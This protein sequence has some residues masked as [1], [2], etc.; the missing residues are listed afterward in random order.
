M[1]MCSGFSVRLRLRSGSLALKSCTARLAKREQ[2]REGAVEH[3]AA[4]FAQEA[5]GLL[6]P[7]AAGANGQEKAEGKRAEDIQEADEADP[8][9]GQKRL[10]PVQLSVEPA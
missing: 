5:F 8:D 4:D 6:L 3:L 2:E 10:M 7:N 9:E 1:T